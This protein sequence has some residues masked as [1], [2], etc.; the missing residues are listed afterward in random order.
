[1]P[2]DKGPKDKKEITQFDIAGGLL[3]TGCVFAVSTLFSRRLLPQI[4]PVSLHLF[5]YMVIFSGLLNI[6]N[7]V[8]DSVKQ[9]AKRLSSL[10]TGPLMGMC[11]VGIGIAF[12]DLGELMMVLNVKT[13]IV[14]AFVILGAVIGSGFAGQLFGFYFVESAMTAGLCMANRGGSGDLQVLGAGKR[15]QLMSYAQISSRIGGAIILLIASVV[16]SMFV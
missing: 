10:F 4:G 12:T 5:A 2:E 16:F 1:M 13:L 15:M 14:C 3:L 9:G 11:M 6:S 8:P 7:V